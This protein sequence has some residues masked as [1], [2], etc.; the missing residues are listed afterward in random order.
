[1]TPELALIFNIAYIDTLLTQRAQGL[2][3]FISHFVNWFQK[4]AFYLP[5]ETTVSVNNT[6]VAIIF[7]TKGSSKQIDLIA[8][9]SNQPCWTRIA[10]LE[11]LTAGMGMSIETLLPRSVTIGLV[12]ILSIFTSMAGSACKFPRHIHPQKVPDQVYCPSHEVASAALR[13]I[14]GR[15][16]LQQSY[17]EVST[18]FLNL[19]QLLSLV[20]TLLYSEFNTRRCF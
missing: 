18:T 6:N 3:Q 13:T 16:T 7:T 5:P 4:T 14:V 8:A 1:M 2:W 15:V 19:L 10:K 17:W 12:A 20:H 9:T 11:Y